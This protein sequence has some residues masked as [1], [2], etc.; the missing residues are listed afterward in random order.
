MP[1]GDSHALR[2]FIGG[3]T[4]GL[5]IGVAG[6]LLATRSLAD[7]EA[8]A[9]RSS[10]L[11]GA[12]QTR[13]QDM[14]AAGNAYLRLQNDDAAAAVYERVLSEFDCAN[15]EARR[16][17]KAIAPDRLSASLRHCGESKHG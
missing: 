15:V 2:M 9:I 4:V 6:A 8:V 10:P 1:T 3:L 13:V 14:L 17:L 16:G 5:V 7:P 11:S 12:D